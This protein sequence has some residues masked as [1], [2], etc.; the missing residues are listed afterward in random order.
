MLS[1]LTEEEWEHHCPQ[2]RYER[3]R[4]KS[5]ELRK[6]FRSLPRHLSHIEPTQ[7][8]CLQQ[9]YQSLRY[10]ELRMGNNPLRQ[11]QPQRQNPPCLHDYHQD[12]TRILQATHLR[13][14]QTT[15]PQRSNNRLKTRIS[16]KELWDGSGKLAS[17]SL[18]SALVEGEE[19]REGKEALRLR[20]H[21]VMNPTQIHPLHPAQL[22]L[23]ARQ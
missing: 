18:A 20:T 23:Q 15:A 6:L 2:R 9:V 12:R 22:R 8:A 16:I 14:H 21:G 5:R 10:D 17:L 4:Q 7:Q 13:P 3:R 19:S 1:R 11:A